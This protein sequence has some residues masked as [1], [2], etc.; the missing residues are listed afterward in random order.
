M[1]SSN[2]RNVYH[3]I[4]A[5]YNEL[6]TIPCICLNKRYYLT[7]ELYTVYADGTR[8]DGNVIS[9]F[10]KYY[11]TLVNIMDTTGYS[12]TDEQGRTNFYGL[13]EINA[14]SN[15]INE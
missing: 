11:D 12:V 7:K 5:Y 6:K 9:D 8:S 13:I 15:C 4:K 10:G 2:E 3:S 1:N 14:F